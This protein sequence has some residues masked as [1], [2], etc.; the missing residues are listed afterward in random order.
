MVYSLDG[1]AVLSINGVPAKRIVEDVINLTTGETDAFRAEFGGSNYFGFYLEKLYKANGVYHIRYELNKQVKTVTINGLRQEVLNARLQR[2]NDSVERVQPAQDVYYTL[3]L[4]DNKTALMNLLEFNELEDFNLFADSAFRVLKEKG[5]D[6]LVIDLR[7]NGGGDS[8]IGD[9]LCQYLAKAPFR[10]Y[11]KVVGKHSQLLKERLKAH[12]VNK[13]MN[14]ADSALM[15]TPDGVF[16]TE[17]YEDIPLR[18]NPLRFKG[19]VY[20]L[21]SAYTFSSAADFAQCFKHYK[22]GTVVGE[23]TGGL[24]VSY[25]DIVPAKLPNTKL[26]LTVSSKLYYNIGSKEGDWRGVI[27]DKVI[28]SGQALDAALAL[29]RQSSL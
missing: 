10:Q 16:E 19:H 25:G 6:N 24:I 13:P 20:L 21:T 17:V 22:M 1:A 18:E 8:D 4:L 3:Q 11:D 28:P 23:E 26:G 27:P 2:Y 15:N 9:E 14:G 5:I 12:R 7:E 29:I